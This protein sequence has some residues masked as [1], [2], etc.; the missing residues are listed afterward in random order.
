MYLNKELPSIP[1][2]PK[3]YRWRVVDGT[4]DHEGGSSTYFALQK[5]VKHEV[6]GHTWK[7]VDYVPLE[8]G[9]SSSCLRIYVATQAEKMLKNL[10][11]HEEF[12]NEINEL[13]ELVNKET[14]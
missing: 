9:Y 14:S 13:K 5:S 10:S 8:E 1:E 12:S 4:S 11:K 7:D 2:A 3:G 6:V